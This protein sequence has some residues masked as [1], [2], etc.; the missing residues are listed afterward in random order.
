VLALLGAFGAAGGACGGAGVSSQPEVADAAGTDAPVAVDAETSSDAQPSGTITI[1]VAS[2][3][4]GGLKSWRVYFN[5][6]SGALV[7]EATPRAD[8]RVIGPATHQVTAVTA[9]MAALTFVGAKEGDVLEALGIEPTPGP[10]T[11]PP[12][13][14]RVAASFPGPFDGASHYNLGI[15]G[16]SSLAYTTDATA[17]TYAASYE[18]CDRDGA[19][20]W[21]T[22]ESESNEVLAY[23]WKA[24][25]VASATPRNVTLGPWAP[26]VATTLTIQNPPSWAPNATVT[27]SAVLPNGDEP[28]LGVASP[29]ANVRVP[30]GFATSYSLSWFQ[31]DRSAELAHAAFVWK[32]VSGPPFVLDL[33]ES[34]PTPASLGQKWGDDDRLEATW[35]LSGNAQLA[36]TAV[37]ANISIAT[38][39]TPLGVWTF[40][41]PPKTTRVVTPALPADAFYR[42]GRATKLFGVTVID[43]DVTGGYD[44]ARRVPLAFGGRALE[45]PK[46][47]PL[48][49]RHRWSART[50]QP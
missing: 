24:G 19:L 47:P 22:A 5:D 14:T 10:D 1:K 32:R 37:V 2:D 12:I 13:R 46:S 39:S 44:A 18:T 9:G 41:L 48:N 43:S 3:V 4:P 26:T 36:A 11:I 31:Q 21:A 16:C 15:G 7:A 25:L 27:L 40:V 8:G 38:P 29:I 42:G 23:A 50:G 20:A 49:G 30:I 35:T 28:S 45:V 17:V 6:A 33:D 34:L